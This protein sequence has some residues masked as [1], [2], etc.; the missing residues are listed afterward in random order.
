MATR[1]PSIAQQRLARVR[2][3]KE[4]YYTDDLSLEERLEVKDDRVAQLEREVAELRARLHAERA[5]RTEPEPAPPRK[6]AFD[7]YRDD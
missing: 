1:R 5:E 7:F 2:A 4:Q 6:P 3:I